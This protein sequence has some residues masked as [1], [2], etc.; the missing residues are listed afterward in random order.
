MGKIETK[1]LNKIRSAPRN[2][3]RD[4]SMLLQG[5][6]IDEDSDKTV[7]EQLRD[8]LSKAAV[9]VIDLFREWGGPGRFEPQTQFDLRMD[10]AGAAPSSADDDDSG[11]VTRKEF[12]RAMSEMKFDV[13]REEIDAL[14]SEWDPDNSGAL[15]LKELSRLL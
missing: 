8:A 10:S 14:F 1:A 11:T 7:A 4:N 3:Q 13:P 5:F 15:E 6:D 12:H 9:K 2:V